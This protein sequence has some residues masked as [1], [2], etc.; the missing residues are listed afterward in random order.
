MR[1]TPPPKPTRKSRSRS[2]P[3]SAAAPLRDSYS[4]ESPTGRAGILTLHGR[5]ES[6]L[7]ELTESDRERALQLLAD[8][9]ACGT[10]RRHALSWLAR[11]LAE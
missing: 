7:D 4:D 1:G 5:I 8:W 10:E 11:M 3:S 9:M 2:S 6:K